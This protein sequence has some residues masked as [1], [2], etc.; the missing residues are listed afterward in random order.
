MA[1][2]DIA[3]HLEV[4]GVRTDERVLQNKVYGFT[5]WPGR[6]PVMPE[7]RASPCPQV[8]ETVSAW[9]NTF[10]SSELQ[11]SELEFESSRAAWH[12]GC[13]ELFDVQSPR[14]LCFTNHKIRRL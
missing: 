9:H 13:F 10:I 3:R 12:G 1:N 5:G 4:H 2:E 7:R 6:V 8:D 14:F 11:N